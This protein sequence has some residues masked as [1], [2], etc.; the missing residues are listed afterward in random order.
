MHVQDLINFNKNYDQLTNI[1][2]DS[3]Q[4]SK[5]NENTNII[6]YNKLTVIQ[7]KLFKIDNND[8]IEKEKDLK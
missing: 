1:N 8:V 6:T 3:C 5:L 7:L 4:A 2:C